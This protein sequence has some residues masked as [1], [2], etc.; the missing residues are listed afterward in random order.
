MGLATLNNGF[1]CPKCGNGTEIGTT[2]LDGWN[3]ELLNGFVFVD[4]TC[5]NCKAEYT[6]VYRFDHSEVT[7][8]EEA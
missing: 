6:N 4:I 3:D 1:V 8:K 2:S 7:Y 5:P